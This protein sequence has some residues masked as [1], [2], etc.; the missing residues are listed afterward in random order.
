MRDFLCNS[1]Y[2]GVL[3]SL[4]GYFLGV[5]LKKRF[6]LGWLNP[7][8][9]AI[10]FVMG[11]LV[12][13]GVDYESYNASAS[14]ISFLLTP[15][16]VCLAVPLYEQLAL[17]K[18]NWKAIFAG[19]TAGVAASLCSVLALSWL[20]GL[21]HR[22]YVTLLPKSITTAI[23]I[24]VTEKLGGVVTI[25]VAVIVVT[26]VLG[27]IAGVGLCRLLRIR[28]PIAVG[29]ALGSAAHAIG[30]AKALE[31]GEVQGAVSSLAVAVAGILTVAGAAVFSR[32]L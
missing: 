6:S 3:V 30:T 9:V 31:L 11:A 10:V 29:L 25:T 5:A 14:H 20:F 22:Y 13:L 16:T 18:K 27:N 17:L 12:L 7:L 32:F 24:G 28:E 26:G 4:T 1:A 15:A 23:A 8:L 21:E 2:F 19:V